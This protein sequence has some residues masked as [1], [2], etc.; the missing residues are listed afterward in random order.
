VSEVEGGEQK[1]KNKAGHSIY[2]TATSTA[3]RKLS[4]TTLFMIVHA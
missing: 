3:A 1:G 2:S 4:L